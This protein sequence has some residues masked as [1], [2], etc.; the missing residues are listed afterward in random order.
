LTPPACT[1]HQ[2]HFWPSAP[3]PLCRGDLVGSKGHLRKPNLC[4]GLPRHR[5]ACSPEATSVWPDGGSWPPCGGQAKRSGRAAPRSFLPRGGLSPLLT[6]ERAGRIATCAAAKSVAGRLPIGLVGT[7][8]LLLLGGSAGGV[9]AGTAMLLDAA[10]QLAR[11]AFRP[12][13]SVHV[14]R[15]PHQRDAVHRPGYARRAGARRAHGRV[16][17]R[18]VH[19]RGGAGGLRCGACHGARAPRPDAGGNTG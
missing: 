13:D 19:G 15:P 6:L 9:A 8:G 12:G 14:A 5:R 17:R 16:P 1:I 10:V 7:A 4:S 3:H 2:R 11:I 18:G